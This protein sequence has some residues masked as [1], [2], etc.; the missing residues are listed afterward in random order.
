MSNPVLVVFHNREEISDEENEKEENKDYESHAKKISID[1]M[2]KDD[3]YKVLGLDDL[4]WRAT[5]EQV[6]SAYRKLA[7]KYH[8]D[9]LAAPTP[10]DRQ[11]FLKIQDAYDILGN[12]EKRRAYFPFPFT[13]RYDS[14]GVEL[15]L[16]VYN[17]GDDFFEC[18]SDAFTQY[19][20]FSSIQPA[21]FI[22]FPLNHS[23]LLGSL[24][25]PWEEVEA[26]YKFW[27]E[28]KSWRVYS[29]FDEYNPEVLLPLLLHGRK[30]SPAG[31]SVG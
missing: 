27:R 24:D 6:R 15:K 22:S 14:A 7:L 12:I 16:P 3:Y 21:Y 29:A 2:I 25:T 20:R 13:S 4:K 9:K 5:D 17:T 30:L 28:F 19:S 8:P 10:E 23:P 18:F 1:D 31:R 26:F 11:I